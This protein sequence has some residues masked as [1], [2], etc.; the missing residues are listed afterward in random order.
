M[1][2]SAQQLRPAL[3][4]M[5][6]G[7]V[8]GDR[9]NFLLLVIQNFSTVACPGYELLGTPRRTNKASTSL[10]ATHG[11]PMPPRRCTHLDP[12]LRPSLPPPPPSHG[13]RHEYITAFQK[14][15]SDSGSLI[16]PSPCSPGH[17]W[18][19]APPRRPHRER[20]SLPPGSKP[21]PQKIMLSVSEGRGVAM[22]PKSQSLTHSAAP[23][24]VLIL[25]FWRGPY[26]PPQRTA[27]VNAR[28]P[29][30]RCLPP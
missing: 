19:D 9:F 1:R 3:D 7:R 29:V 6:H 14:L 16:P 5:G 2:Y 28:L 20:G 23:T 10:I 30:K 17:A 12:P 13:Q 11:S 24:P 8:R 18:E 25:S 4:R 26:E 15:M 22:A 27:A 21:P